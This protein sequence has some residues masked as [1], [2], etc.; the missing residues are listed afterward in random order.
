MKSNKS[1]FLSRCNRQSHSTWVHC[2]SNTGLFPSQ[3]AS[4][5]V[6]SQLLWMWH[7]PTSSLLNGSCNAHP[8]REPI[9]PRQRMTGNVHL[10]RWA[11]TITC[12]ELNNLRL[13]DLGFLT[14]EAVTTIINWHPVSVLQLYNACS[15]P[16]MCVNCHSVPALSV[17]LLFWCIKIKVATTFKTGFQWTIKPFTTS[18]TSKTDQWS[19]FL[20]GHVQL[21]YSYK[22]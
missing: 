5:R 20:G 14:F 22:H 13:A 1:P 18:G 4:R 19:I 3:H 16:R 8:S 2:G 10:I 9:M 15:H 21:E 11:Q 12:L 6:P 7:T 17:E